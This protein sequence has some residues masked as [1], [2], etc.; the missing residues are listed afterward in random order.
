MQ[1]FVREATSMA[2]LN[3]VFPTDG[4]NWWCREITSKPHGSHELKTIPAQHKRR[5]PNREHRCGANQIPSKC[6]VRTLHNS[7]VPELGW[8]MRTLFS[9]GFLGFYSSVE[10]TFVSCVGR[11]FLIGKIIINGR[12]L[13]NPPHVRILFILG[14]YEL[15]LIVRCKLFSFRIPWR[16]LK[17]SGCH[18][19]SRPVHLVSVHFGSI[20]YQPTNLEPSSLFKWIRHP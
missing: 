20:H 14:L 7:R 12:I 9:E 18:V 11:R 2:Y 1:L 19:A 15:G 17:P 4:A 16:P 3:N 8:I 6:Q 5:R 13:R 10:P